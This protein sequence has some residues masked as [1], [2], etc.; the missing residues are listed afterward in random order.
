[1]AAAPAK[2]TPARIIGRILSLT[3]ALVGLLDLV[4]A[5]AR[6]L[7]PHRRLDV[8]LG[9]DEPIAVRDEP[10]LGLDLE[11]QRRQDLRDLLADV[12]AGEELPGLARDHVEHLVLGAV[13]RRG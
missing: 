12:E 7:E 10:D 5:I 6:A 2:T 11:R 1:M 3:L 8:R 4:R 13:G 9:A